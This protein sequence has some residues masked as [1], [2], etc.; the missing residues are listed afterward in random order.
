MAQRRPINLQ[1]ATDAQFKAINS[2]DQSKLRRLIRKRDEKGLLSKEDCVECTGLSME[3]VEELITQNMVDF[4]PVITKKELVDE[5]KTQLEPTLRSVKDTQIELQEAQ[6]KIMEALSVIQQA[7]QNKET[8]ITQIDLQKLKQELST[9]FNN[10]LVEEIKSVKTTQSKLQESQVKIMEALTAIQQAPQIKEQA[11]TPIDLLKLK[12]ELSTEFKKELV[13]EVRN[14]YEEIA[15]ISITPVNITQEW[16]NFAANLRKEIAEQ[17][18][19]TREET[20]NTDNRLRKIQETSI[21][22]INKDIVSLSQ[23][24]STLDR[25]VNEASSEA[26][27]ERSIQMNELKSKLENMEE[28]VDKQRVENSERLNCLSEEVVHKLIVNTQVLD[29][30]RR[31]MDERIDLCKRKMTAE[32][33]KKQGEIQDVIFGLEVAITEPEV[34]LH[35]KNED[36]NSKQAASNNE[37]LEVINNWGTTHQPNKIGAPLTSLIRLGH[38]SPA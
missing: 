2:I 21:T 30:Q 14:I 22:Q 13:A 9:E 25:K 8:F 37:L 33:L 6:I 7:S 11:I 20:K 18:K 34:N 3:E 10:K 35:N 19:G 28:A 36:A 15:K 32:I 16:Q 5:I 29:G 4:D 38:H 26:K 23:K 31:D 1:I 12:Q 17:L 24:Y 27:E